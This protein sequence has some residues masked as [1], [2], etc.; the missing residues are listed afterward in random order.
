MR[1]KGQVEKMLTSFMAEPTTIMNMVVDSYVQMKRTGNKKQFARTIGSV[2]ASGVANAMLVS[3]V[4]AARDDD[5]DESHLEKYRQALDGAMFDAI[6]PL[7]YFPVLRDIMSLFEGF[8]VERADMATLSDVFDAYERCIEDGSDWIDVISFIA[9]IPGLVGVPTKNLWRE[10]KSIINF[11]NTLKFN[12][13]PISRLELTLP[14]KYQSQYDKYW[15]KGYTE[16]ECESKALSYVKSEI[17]SSLKS[18]YLTALADKDY[19][20][21]KNIRNYMYKSG[22]YESLS[23]IDKRLAE[24]RTGK[25]EEE[26]RSEVAKTR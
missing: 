2:V 5:E 15:E 1:S 26:K 21:S 25:D 11:Y 13:N 17:T 22:Y 18:D 20:T 23:E 3:L 14:Q 6:V 12:G 10:V 19:E 7:N 4:Y 16:A 24:W 8:D 9:T